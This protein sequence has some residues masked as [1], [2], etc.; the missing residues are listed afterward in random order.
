MKERL[1]SQNDLYTVRLRYPHQSPSIEVLS[2]LYQPLITPIAQSLY[3]RLFSEGE[4]VRLTQS[5]HSDLM[6]AMNLDLKHLQQAFFYLE[7]IGLLKTY[8]KEQSGTYH[9]IYQLLPP[10]TAQEFFSDDIM[11]FL[12]SD[13]LGEKQVETLKQ[14]FN[15]ESTLPKGYKEVTSDFS[16]SYMFSENRY[17]NQPPK[18]I[19]KPQKEQVQWTDEEEKWFERFVKTLDDR[20]VDINNIMYHQSTILLIKKLYGFKDQDLQQ[21]IHQSINI[22]HGTLDEGKLKSLAMRAGRYVKQTSDES[23]IEPSKNIENSEQRK[24]FEVASALSPMQFLKEIRDEHHGIITSSE[25]FLLTNLAGMISSEALNLI[26][27]YCLVIK[28]EKE[29]NQKRV[30]SIVNRLKQANAVDMTSIW[31]RLPEIYE[32]LTTFKT[33]SHSFKNQKKVTK[34]EWET[35]KQTPVIEKSTEEQQALK[36][37]QA[38]LERRIQ[39]MKGGLQ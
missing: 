3:L 31:H 28:G 27:Y 4:S 17:K 29:L 7:G 20:F 26:I 10:V 37:R 33:Y 19:P 32:G 36:A 34:P 16:D 14:Y 38:E 11:T 24:L 9:F 22:Q 8:Q 39:A 12:L 25:Q 23:T 30:E 5:Y 2:L 15:I 18:T 6:L 1:M 35:E 21:L 13:L